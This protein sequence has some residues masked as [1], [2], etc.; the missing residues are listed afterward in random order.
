MIWRV[1]DSFLNSFSTFLNLLRPISTKVLTINLNSFNLRMF[2]LDFLE[3]M[4][5]MIMCL[6]HSNFCIVKSF[7]EIFAWIF[8]WDRNLLRKKICP[9]SVSSD[10]IFSWIMNGEIRSMN[11]L[12]CNPDNLWLIIAFI[13]NKID[14]FISSY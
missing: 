1:I 9:S 8:T 14:V 2:L 13:S 3:N 11:F 10:L 6:F 5:K 7:S 4:F 12:G